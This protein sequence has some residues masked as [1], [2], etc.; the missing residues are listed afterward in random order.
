[1][2]KSL[3]ILP[4]ALS[5]VLASC[6][7]RA[8]EPTTSGSE[9]PTTQVNPSSDSSS[10]GSSSSTSIV[11]P[12]VESVTLDE[13]SI[14]LDAY[15]SEQKQLT[16]TVTA[17]GGAPQTVTWESYPT[18]FV[19]VTNGLVTA[20][21]KGSATVRATSTF[22]T[23][24]YAECT[25]TVSDSNPANNHT[26]KV[27]LGDGSPV[28]LSA[29][30]DV[31]EGDGG[32]YQ[33]TAKLNVTA[34]QAI[35]FIFDDTEAPAGDGNELGQP[36]NGNNTFGTYP[37][38]VVHNN[39]TNADLYFKVYETGYSFWLTGYD[40][41]AP[42]PVPPEPD[43]VATVTFGTK[44][45][46]NMTLMDN[47]PE[48]DG[49]LYQFE[50]TT[51]VTEGDTIAFTLDSSAVQP[52]SDSGSNT[53]G[54]HP[55]Y[56][57]HNNAEGV[58]VYF[59]IYEGGSSF[60]IGGYDVVLTA[61]VKFGEN[62][63]IDMS[64]MDNPPEGDGG[65]YQF[66]A[67][68]NVTAGAS[69]AFTLNGVASEP[70]ADTGNNNVSGTHPNY[71]VHNDAE[72]A[73]IYFKVYTSGISFWITGYEVVPYITAS[74]DGT[75]SKGG[76]IDPTKLVVNYVDGEDV[77]DIRLAAT[78]SYKG[79]VIADPLNYAFAAVGS[80]TIDINYTVSAKD[81]HTTLT[82]QV[83]GEIGYSL[84][85]SELKNVILHEDG[86]D[87]KGRKQFKG[88]AI[89][90]V[91]DETFCVMHTYDESK[92]ICDLDPTS[93]EGVFHEYLSN[94]VEGRFKVVKDFTA[95]VYFKEVYE[96]DQIY[97][98]LV[99]AGVT[100]AK[101]RIDGES[102][103]T[104]TEIDPDP[105]D[106]NML[107]QFKYELTA[108]AGETVEFLADGEEVPVGTARVLGNLNIEAGEITFLHDYAECTIYLKVYEHGFDFYATLDTSV[109]LFSD[110]SSWAKS[111]SFKMSPLEDSD[112]KEQY[113][114]IWEDMAVDTEF[115]I[116]SDRNDIGYIGGDDSHLEANENFDVVTT[117]GL[118]YGNIK[119]KTAGTYKI[120]FKINKDDSIRIYIQKLPAKNSISVTYGEAEIVKGNALVFSKL[121]VIFCDEDYQTQDIK[122]S[123]NVKFY[124]DSAEVDL[125]G[126]T[127]LFNTVGDI[128]I[129]VKAEYDEGKFA[130]TTFVVHVVNEIEMMELNLYI[131]STKGD[132]DSWYAN[133]GAEFYVWYW[134]GEHGNRL[135]KV[136]TIEALEDHRIHLT[137]SI[138]A[139]AT[140]CKLYRCDPHNP[141]ESETACPTSGI[142]N[143]TGDMSIGDNA[144]FHYA[145]GQF[146]N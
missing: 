79:T 49:G 145:D 34:G 55:N 107:Q 23:S 68:T 56:T 28:T 15:T 73:D 130:E 8:E 121:S 6:D 100:T 120:F 32:L 3:L 64:L 83:V 1:M 124:I 9:T 21:K 131:S 19:T 90:F 22:N 86:V 104:M 80:Y 45:P 70:Y 69:I 27:K 126:G 92:F 109:Y 37:N 105:L 140:D 95:S 133:G 87:D 20:V 114:F 48:G 115:K 138:P 4:L 99:T 134:G 53:S 44:T 51:N 75:I 57:V 40:S 81:Y 111:S 72:N 62:A 43:H 123:L 144:G 106:L 128:T 42:D 74:Y 67:T 77:T 137:V 122:N 97:F 110:V 61:T 146:P 88:T 118:S 78:Y 7:D 60:W 54:E 2:K 59:K 14:S 35:S 125:R 58:K 84:Y 117:E 66:K 98:E 91:K 12:T 36:H 102:W 10:S 38:Y 50:A 17:V 132:L 141:P 13:T 26:A 25:V 65:L 139:D 29:M 94:E 63:P 41:T 31:P 18:G 39:A 101:V 135:V 11:T 71:E 143:E 85:F 116:Y 82:V 119:C 33:Y 16:A 76:K 30:K 89:E 5:L 127:Y 103:V 96:A 47:P 93:F 136:S 108:T 112:Y 142:W 24:K 113:T 129:N 52:W 46:I